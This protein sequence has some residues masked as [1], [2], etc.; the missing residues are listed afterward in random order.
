MKHESN[1]GDCRECLT[2]VIRV[3]EERT[4][5]VRSN[6]NPLLVLESMGLSLE[7][8]EL[9]QDCDTEFRGL[10][11]RAVAAVNLLDATLCEIPAIQ[12]IF[13]QLAEAEQ[14]GTLTDEEGRGVVEGAFTKFNTNKPN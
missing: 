6:P 14:Q 11:L 4:D 2:K 8:R 7:V 9:L 3:L 5:E 12:D 1:S 10:R 13:A